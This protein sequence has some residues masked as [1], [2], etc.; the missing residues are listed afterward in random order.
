M[1]HPRYTTRAGPP[2]CGVP[3]YGPRLAMVHPSATLPHRLGC[4]PPPGYGFTVIMAHRS[5]RARSNQG[6]PDA[7]VDR[8]I[9]FNGAVGYTALTR[10]RRWD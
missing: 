4:G 5:P 3:S 7:A 8:A 10:R 9:S 1:P 2:G 6:H